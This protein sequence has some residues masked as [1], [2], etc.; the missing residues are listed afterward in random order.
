MS[1]K[2]VLNEI[3]KFKEEL[4]KEGEI[5]DENILKRVINILDEMEPG[6]IRKLDLGKDEIRELVGMVRYL[7]RGHLIETAYGYA[8]E[9]IIWGVGKQRKYRVLFDLK[10]YWI[11]L[12][13]DEEGYFVKIPTYL[14]RI[15]DEKGSVIYTDPNY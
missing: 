8:F 9:Y 12:Y 10:M 3:R 15:I 4:L 14:P 2:N 1:L 5:S 6:E 7:A 11:G 13:E